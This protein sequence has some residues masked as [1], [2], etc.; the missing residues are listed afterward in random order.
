MMT[1][2]EFLQ[3][4]ETTGYDFVIEGLALDYENKLVKLNDGNDGVDFSLVNNPIY[5]K[6]GN[7]EVISIF[8][9][10][11]LGDNGKY[12]KDGNPMIYELK[13]KFDWKWD[14][15]VEDAKKYIRR[16]YEVCSKLHKTFDTIVVMP[17][18]SNLNNTIAKAISETVNAN[19]IVNTLITK[20]LTEIVEETCIDRKSINNDYKNEKERSNVYDAIIKSFRK[21]GEYFEAKY[22][23][24]KYLKYI[25][26]LNVEDDTNIRPMIDDKDIVIVDDI[27]SS[28]A[29]IRQ[30]IKLIKANFTPKNI[31]VI[32]LLSPKMNK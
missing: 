20:E 28:G 8:K 7:I 18:S 13:H 1:L 32:T 31:T 23:P 26:Y 3:Q 4:G 21:M 12:D 6:I 9:R 2:V 5:S 11:P 30:T 25:K 24:K 15:S 10:T 19:N 17:S 22:V 16:F 29:S 14:M 27:I